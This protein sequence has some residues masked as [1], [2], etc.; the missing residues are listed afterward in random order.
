MCEQSD[1]GDGGGGRS[2]SLRSH[3]KVH[4]LFIYIYFPVRIVIVWLSRV[5]CVHT[6]SSDW[7]TVKTV[8]KRLP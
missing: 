7:Q 4:L 8:C 2:N 6:N 5:C 3:H 1:S